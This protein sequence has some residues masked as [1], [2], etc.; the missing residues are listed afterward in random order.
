M[1]EM[2]EMIRDWVRQYGPVEDDVKFYPGKFGN[3][4]KERLLE[5]ADMVERS[6]KASRYWPVDK[7]GVELEPG[8]VVHL[9]HNGMD[10]EVTCMMLKRDGKWVIGCDDGG[11]FLMPDSEDD[12]TVLTEDMRLRDKLYDLVL[13][14]V[15]IS[16]YRTTDDGRNVPVLACDG[17]C[18]DDWM[19]E[20]EGEVVLG[21]QAR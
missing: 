18:L 7:N 2:A 4:G 11:P 1:N 5:I 12:V 3:V 9:D 10:R 8:C 15:S 20:H 6:E 16:G 21:D 17:D 14:C 13:S 19:S